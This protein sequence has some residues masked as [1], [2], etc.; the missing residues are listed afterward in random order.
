VALDGVGLVQRQECNKG[1]AIWHVQKKER[2]WRDY[3]RH[4]PQNPICTSLTMFNNHAFISILAG[5][6]YITWAYQHHSTWMQL[7]WAFAG[8]LTSK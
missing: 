6:N 3:P 4:S 1:Y 7:G 5:E 2:S 8:L